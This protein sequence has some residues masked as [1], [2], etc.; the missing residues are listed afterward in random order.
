[1]HREQGVLCSLALII[2]L[3]SGL[4]VAGSPA[5]ISWN[6]N[7]E[8]DLAGYRVYYGT[9]ADNYSKVENVGNVTTY[10]IND[11]TP[12][13]TYYFVVTAY[14]N[15]GNESGY[16]SE[17]TLNIPDTAPPFISAVSASNL[18][19]TGATITWATDEPAD[20]QVDYGLDTNYGSTTPLNTQPVTQHSVTLSG[21]NASTTYHFRVNSRDAAGHLATSGDFAFTTL[22]PDATPPQI[23]NVVAGSLSHEGATITWTTDEPTDSE[24]EFGETATYGQTT[25]ATPNLVTAH[26]MT[27][28]GLNASTTYHFRVKSRD[29]A[30]NLAMSLDQTF[31]T[32]ASP[33]YVR[34]VN[35]G[36]DVY[37]DASGKGWSADQAYATGT[38]WGHDYGEA[39]VSV[40]AIDRTTEDVLYQS[41]R[42]GAGGYRFEAPAV[43][44]YRVKLHFAEIVHNAPRQ[45]VFDVTLEN[46][47]VI[48]NLDLFATFGMNVA[49][50]YT[51]DVEVMDGRL[52][53]KF[54]AVT[55]DPTISAIEVTSIE[56]SGN[57]DV[58]SPI[59]ISAALTGGNSLRVVFNEAVS[60][61]SAQTVANY[62]IS[63]TVAILSATL[64]GDQRTVALATGNHVS[65]QN[66]TLTVRNIADV[67]TPPNVM[68]LAVNLNY[69]YQAV[70]STPPTAVS[71][72]MLGR[73]GLSVQFSEPVTVTT[74]QNKTNYTI[75]PAVEI[76]SASL[77]ADQKTVQLA[78]ANHVGGQNYTLAVRNISDLATP[79]NVMTSASTLSYSYQAGDATPPAVV[80]VTALDQNSVSVLFGEAVSVASAQNKSNYTI[81]PDLIIDRA[82]LQSDSRTVILSTASHANGGSYALTVRN[83]GDR[84]QTPNVMTTPVTVNYVYQTQDTTPPSIVGATIN[85]PTR[86]VVVFSEKVT[87]ASA[88]AVAN[89]RISDGVTVTSA[90][91]AANGIEVELTTTS[92]Q[93][94]H[95]YLL[96]V[97]NVR[98]RSAAGNVMA[99]NSSVS[100]RLTGQGNGN[101]GGLVVN[102]LNL[103]NYRIDSLRV[104]DTYYVD[105]SYRINHI[106]AGKRRAMWIKTANADKASTSNFFLEFNLNREADVYI[107]YDSRATGVPQWLSRNF[108]KTNEYVG[109]SET[110]GRMDL[111]RGHFL[112]GRVQLGGNLASGAA[113]VNSMYFVLIDDLRNPADAD[114]QA[115]RSF[116]LYQNYPNPFNPKTEISFYIDRDA[117]VVVNIYNSLGQLVRTLHEGRQSQGQHRLTWDARDDRGQVMPSGTYLYTL[118]IRDQMNSGGV[119]LSSAISR[120]SRSMTLLK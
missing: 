100:Y 55:G 57:D 60:A 70:D 63:P 66:Y 53:V 4:A 26:Q 77:Q 5:T 59:P 83:V 20:G 48:D 67:T 47:L 15:S 33:N 45:R 80:N 86:L 115:P 18:T 117:Y 64:Q 69:L 9:S 104:G 72:N 7:S 16:S 13:V 111:W 21:L 76:I 12:G 84:A 11:L 85:T 88:Q 71:V 42:H 22:A 90:V 3:F 95:D 82:V 27:I 79:P 50:T 44:R 94:D 113:N 10:V 29:G 75:T 118:E 96:V 107:A 101:G 8:S 35:V 40:N 93:V 17:A 98:D 32:T 97:N 99:P 6:A 109:V 91:A 112:P 81:T 23:T 43:G 102:S 36:G 116:V 41:A 105:R 74:A 89:Y 24:V 30:G 51:F 103:G 110:A 28:S 2:F 58:A 49:A 78:T 73:N 120:Q 19:T 46:R 87:V 92:H 38:E 65:G 106:P 61:A 31:T 25:G 54:V 108:D 14:D 56:T 34:R 68:G 1:M 52:A 114:P 119:T 62:S 39:A 37:T